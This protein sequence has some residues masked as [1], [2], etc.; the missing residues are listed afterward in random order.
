MQLIEFSSTKDIN[1]CDIFPLAPTEINH[2]DPD[3]TDKDKSSQ[4]NKNH[5]WK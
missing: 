3:Q 2:A 1:N 5:E 4:Q